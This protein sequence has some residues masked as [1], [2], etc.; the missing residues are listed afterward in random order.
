MRA[1][2][3]MSED[4]IT[5]D[6]AKTVRDCIEMMSALGARHVPV[7]SAGKLV[8]IVSDRDVRQYT[9][10]VSWNQFAVA[11]D[12]PNAAVLDEPVTA[13]MSGGTLCVELETHITK[14]VD[15]ICDN[16]VGALPVVDADRVVIGIVSYVDVLR[17]LR[18]AD[19]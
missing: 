18:P 14:V 16:R 10:S 7:T 15:L 5:I 8:G 13:I 19:P 1:K 17:A 12:G 4:P 11:E 9:V 3:V 6:E 2:D